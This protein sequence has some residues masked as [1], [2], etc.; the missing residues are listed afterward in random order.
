MLRYI[1]GLSLDDDIEDM[2]ILTVKG[3]YDAAEE[4]GI[5]GLRK[6]VPSKL[7]ERLVRF[8]DNLPYAPEDGP[9]LDTDNRL[10]PF[11][12]DV[13]KLLD[14]RD[15]NDEL[16]NSEMMRVTVKICCKYFAIIRQWDQFQALACNHPE[17]H[18]S[19]LYYA[20]AKGGN[21]LGT[22]PR[23]G[24]RVAVPPFY[25]EDD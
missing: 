14:A 21:L 11:V 8:L 13:E 23:T 16:E 17:L 22:D 15:P 9:P 3:L 6:Y 18:T 12:D 1:Y 24:A 4:L 25:D 20:A 10:D 2:E 7:E 19:I 5:P